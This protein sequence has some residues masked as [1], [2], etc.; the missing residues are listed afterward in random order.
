MVRGT[1]TSSNESMK[2]NKKQNKNNKKKGT[3]AQS[4]FQKNIEEGHLIERV[5]YTTCRD[6]SDTPPRIT[7]ISHLH[8]KKDMASTTLSEVF[9]FLYR[10]SRRRLGSPWVGPTN[11]APKRLKLVTV[12]LCAIST[13]SA[14]FASLFLCRCTDAFSSSP[15][16]AAINL[17][18]PS[19][20]VLHQT[21]RS[22]AAVLQSLVMPN[23]R[24][25]SATQSVHYFSFPPG[26]RFP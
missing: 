21:P 6:P 4:T 24:R 22:S 14:S 19:R 20:T 7:T 8:P 11:A 23:S 9:I 25:S 12:T 16:Y 17:Q 13:L 2:T 10:Y 18:P 26:P 1:S 3:I 5:W 15:T